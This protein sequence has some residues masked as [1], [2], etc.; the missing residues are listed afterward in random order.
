M[1]CDGCTICCDLLPVPVLNKASYIRCVHCK[2]SKCMI[3]DHKPDYCTSYDCMY[4]QS[5][6]L[7]VSLRPDKCG[8]VFEKVNDKLILSIQH[9][10]MQPTVMATN[11]AN[12]FVKQGF[13]VA[14]KKKD[15]RMQIFLAKGHKA[16]EIE[17]II[18][19][20]TRSDGVRN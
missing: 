13:S 9:P 12:E 1:E 2:L 20:N 16:K 14:I 19:K 3:H 15:N 8:I 6:K 10:D 11:Q 4:S 18:V 5:E 7:P 17:D